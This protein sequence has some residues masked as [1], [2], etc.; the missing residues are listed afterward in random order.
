MKFWSLFILIITFIS[1]KYDN[2]T[3]TQLIDFVPEETFAIVSIDN[4]DDLNSGLNNNDMYGLISNSNFH[5]ELSQKLD[6]FIYFKPTH[7]TL[8]CFS[9]D[10]NNY[11]HYTLITKN[12][13]DIL[14]TD[15][16]TNYIGETLTYKNKKILKHTTNNVFYSTINDSILMISTS[17]KLIENS[18]TKKGIHPEL[19]KLYHTSD[20]EKPLSVLLNIKD[21][22]SFNS[23]FVNDSIKTKHLSNYISVDIDISQKEIL[24]NGVTKAEDSSESLINIFKNLIPQKNQMASITPSSADGFLS[25]TFNDYNLFKENLNKFNRIDSLDSSTFLFDNIKEVGIIYEE[26]EKAVILNSIDSG[27][28]QE[29][30]L[31]E[32]SLISNFR[33]TDIFSFSDKDLFLE[34]FYP[35][36]TFDKASHYCIIENFFVFGD[37]IEILQNIIS[38]YQNKTTFDNGQYY[39]DIESQLSDQSSFLTAVNGIGLKQILIKNLQ[40]NLDINLNDYRASAL[41]FVYDNNFAHVNGV[42]K[43][44]SKKGL[45]YSVS[46]E[47]N[48]KLDADLLIDPQLVTNHYSKE[49]EIVVQDINN[50]LYL[51]SNKGKILWKKRING[52]VLG[53]I[54]QI[55]IY[56]NGRLQLLFAT[57]HR[58]YL[59]DRNGNDVAPFPSNFNDEITQP[60]SVFDYDN[61]KNYRLLVTQGKNVIMYNA[62]ARVVKGF[63]FKS[64]KSEII[65]QPQHFRIGSKDYIVIKTDDQLYILNRTG[66][67]RINPKTSNNYSDQL[68]YIYKNKFTTTSKDGQLISIDEKGNVTSQNL[69]ISELHS[70]DATSKT[71]VAQ[72]ENKLRIKDR[73]VELDYGTY[74][75]PKIF[76]INDKIYVSVTDLQAQKIYLFDSQAKMLSNFPVYG[77]SQIVLDKIDTDNNLE[78]ITKGESNGILIYKIN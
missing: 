39:K 55:D 76:Y 41:Q 49:K 36:I 15:S 71:L 17:L 74:S 54:E 31:S 33:Q 32:Q 44:S 26:G 56:K 48:I 62:L 78:F 16:L 19:E 66:K 38:S 45:E 34:V 6:L 4:F 1:C 68:V 51:I 2:T 8:L 47:L 13:H 77:N 25:F 37:T 57:P 28:T 27:L 64:A 29:A 72:Y 63:T 67:A 58:I 59:I 35:L 69:N 3:S 43:K 46:E 60:L 23:F 61:K 11:T 40:E 42:I 9:K 10:E 53:K 24:I 75:K 5:H 20:Q 73:I 14:Q 18:N 7:K 30:L 65:Q 52:Q 70:I 22:T 12:E 50:N 21:K